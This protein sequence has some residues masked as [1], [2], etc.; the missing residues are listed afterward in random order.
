MAGGGRLNPKTFRCVSSILGFLLM[1]LL[2]GPFAIP[3]SATH[4]SWAGP[5]LIETDG[6]ETAYFPDVAVDAEGNAFAVWRQFPWSQNLSGPSSVWANRFW[7]GYGWGTAEELGEGE[8]SPYGGRGDAAPQVAVALQGIAIAVWSGN[9]RIWA[10]YMPGLAPDT[11]WAAASPIQGRGGWAERPQIAMDP[12]GRAL[13]VWNEL[14]GDQW[15]LW[16]GWFH[17][18]S[19][20]GELTQIT[21]KD[22]RTSSPQLAVSES[23]K[24]LAIWTEDP[25]LGGDNWTT[26]LVARAFAPGVGWSPPARLDTGHCLWESRPAMSMS[27]SGNGVAV[28]Y[29]GRAETGACSYGFEGDAIWA[30]SFTAD[31]R[32]GIPMKGPSPQVSLYLRAPDVAVDATGNATVVWRDGRIWT[33]S[34]SPARGWGPLTAVADLHSDGCGLWA[35]DVIRPRVAVDG[36]GRALAVWTESWRTNVTGFAGCEARLVASSF[37]P[38]AGWG[39]ATPISPMSAGLYAHRQQDIAII[40]DRGPIVVW[41]G[42]EEVAADSYRNGIWANRVVDLQQWVGDT[43]AA[44]QEARDALNAANERLAELFT[45]AVGLFVL[46]VASVATFSLLLL[47]FSGRGGLAFRVGGNPSAPPGGPTSSNG[48]SAFQGA[49]VQGE[50]STVSVSAMAI[51]SPT[52]RRGQRP[53]PAIASMRITTKERILLHLMQYARNTEELEAPPDLT[54]EGIAAAVWID[55]RHLSQYV[56][57]LLQD[58]L[59]RVQTAHVRNG[60]QRRKVY[61][62]TETGRRIAL[63]LQARAE[64]EVVPVWDGENVWEVRVGDILVK[65][66]GKAHVLDVARHLAEAGVVDFAALGANR[67]DLSTKADLADA[68][69]PG[70]EHVET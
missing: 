64:S 65:R 16:A 42:V 1:S 59:V 11:A 55:Q 19:G 2:V 58:G 39:E 49:E 22:Y 48:P 33:S 68:K 40:P 29:G 47:R 35:E 31:G 14:I 5:L 8:P 50:T 6:E 67:K 46:F 63:R 32:W 54:Q 45:I 23:G 10:N 70:D 62:L 13:V 69:A 43:D 57:P 21:E 3:A 18:I 66:Q 28:W 20:W 15:S 25:P 53:L 30:T 12:S 37:V 17:P 41:S 51:R 44:L 34:F 24:A 27:T 4:G 36:T 60:H 7:P 56:D 9:G 38:G 26:T 61:R 52:R